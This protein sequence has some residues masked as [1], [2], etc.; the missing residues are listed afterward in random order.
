MKGRAQEGGGGREEE[1]WR[2]LQVPPWRAREEDEGAGGE[3]GD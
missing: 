2:I 1:E 3:G